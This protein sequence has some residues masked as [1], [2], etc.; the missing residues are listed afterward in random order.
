MEILGS[1]FACNLAE[2]NC[3]LLD[4]FNLQDQVKAFEAATLSV[5][6]LLHHQFYDVHPRMGQSRDW[7][8]IVA[9]CPTGLF[10]FFVHLFG[11]DWLRWWEAGRPEVWGQDANKVHDLLCKLPV[12]VVDPAILGHAVDWCLADIFQMTEVNYFVF[13]KDTV[14]ATLHDY[15][16]KHN[17]RLPNR[18]TAVQPSGTKSLLTNASPG[19]HAPKA[20]RFIRRITFQAYD[21][22][23]LACIDYGY[24]VIPSQSCKDENG[25]LLDDPYDPRV[26]EWLIEIPTEMN[27]KNIEGEY[28]MSKFS[29][30]AQFSFYMQVQ[31]YYTTHNTSFTW[32]F[33]EH[34]IPEMAE[35]L[36]NAIE[37]ERGYISVACLARFDANETFPRL[38]FEPI[39][40]AKY[41]A[42]QAEV[43]KRRKSDDFASLMRQYDTGYTQFEG[44]MACDSDKCLMPE[45]PK[46]APSDDPF[47]KEFG[48]AA[49]K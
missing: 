36:L 13:W 22:V 14:R 48:A 31:E 23:A 40:K 4:P 8:P 3:N 5:A 9:V 12:E 49:T 26:S 33:R 34:E 17:L 7:D 39:T 41:E 30:M 20:Q 11:D 43:L 6:S 15:C 47:L 38:P 16:K 18:Y 2:V 25:K 32:E 21:P 24:N 46:S 35:A 28:D 45:R 42:L 44:P 10:D 1:D 27:W 37:N 29:A 19:A